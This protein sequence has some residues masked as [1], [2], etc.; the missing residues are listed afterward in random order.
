MGNL[1]VLN[2]KNNGLVLM[3][4][5]TVNRVVLIVILMFSLG[6]YT[7]EEEPMA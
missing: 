5:K 7:S 2:V 1:L 6:I 3:L 4:G